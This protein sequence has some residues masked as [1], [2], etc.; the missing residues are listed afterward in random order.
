MTPPFD[1][2]RL[3]DGAASLCVFDPQYHG[4]LDK[5]AYGKEGARQKDR[6][7]LAQMDNATIAAFVAENTRTLRPSG[8]LLLWTD[9][10]Q[11]CQDV[12]PWLAGTSLSEV[13]LIVWEKTC[14]VMGDRSRR[15]SKYLTF[16]QKVP[17]RA[18]RAW[19]DRAIPDVWADKVGAGH[20]HRKPVE[21]QRHLV[22]A[23]IVPGDLVLDPVAGGFSML[24]AVKGYAELR[25]FLG[26][27]LPA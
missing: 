4:V 5:M 26:K 27:D 6:V 18:K 21:I 2:A 19:R 8:H 9:K 1:P 10:F 3:P 16:L 14:I 25:V 24:E 12:A 13:V 15:R 20:P 23:V 17:L 22:E 7:A 11:L